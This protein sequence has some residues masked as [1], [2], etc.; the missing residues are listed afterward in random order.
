MKLLFSL[1]DRKLLG[2]HIVGEGA[3]E[4]IH[5]GQAVL[6][7]GGTI[8]YFVENAFNYPTLAEGYKIAAL[9]AYNRM[10]PALGGARFSRCRVAAPKRVCAEGCQ[11]CLVSQHFLGRE[12][13]S[14][15]TGADCRDADR[16]RAFADLADRGQRQAGLPAAE[17][18]DI[19]LGQDFRVEQRAV[20]GAGA[21]V[22]ARSGR[23]ARRDCSASSG[24]A[25]ARASAC[26]RSDAREAPRG[27]RAKT[28]C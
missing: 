10:G 13:R 22:D 11:K 27:R 19:D 7:L 25:G 1:A 4:L 20:L 28:P 18:L 6:N 15:R 3:T 12:P 23:R 14:E 5:I 21:G 9:D 17:K 16:R 8:D 24:G 2:A 26:R